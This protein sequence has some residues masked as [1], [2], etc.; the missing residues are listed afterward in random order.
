MPLAFGFVGDTADKTKPN[1]DF[2]CITMAKIKY[3]YDTES[4]RYERIKVTRWDIFWNSLGFLAISAA[5]GLVMLLVYTVYFESS[6]EA[7]LRKENA[8]LKFHFDLLAKDLVSVRQ[9]LESIQDRDD[10][11]YRVMLGADPIPS[12]IRKAGF[13]GSDRYRELSGLAQEKLIRSNY[14]QIGRLK[15]QLYIQT[16]SYDEV[17]D[18]AKRKEEMLSSMPAIQPVSNKELKW[19]TSGFG[20]RIDPIVR[21]RRHH[22]G[23]DYSIA[24]GTP[25]YATGD[26]VVSKVET[27]FNGYGKQIEINHGF[28]YQTKYAH[29]NGFKVVRGQKVKRGEL[30]GY[31]GSTGKSTGAHLHYEVMVNSKKV[32]PIYYMYRD[33]TPEEYEEILR[34]GHIENIAQDSY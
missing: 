12:D 17:V 32:N 14:E 26:G 4:C 16:K 10:N 19:L 28:G 30:I 7:Q 21:T 33:L 20:W 25:V 5:V 13:G 1:S 29:L 15:K 11:I 9:M 24:V 23:V 31:S 34:L 2:G 8:D 6:E 3:Y 22:S 18:L 27:K